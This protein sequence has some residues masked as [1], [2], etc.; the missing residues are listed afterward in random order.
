[1]HHISCL[2][3]FFLNQTIPYFYQNH[4]ANESLV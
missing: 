3:D 2:L 4:I 1:L